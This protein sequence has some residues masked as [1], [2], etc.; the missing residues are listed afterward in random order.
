MYEALVARVRYHIQKAEFMGLKEAE[1]TLLLKET[2]DAIEELQS[3]KAALNGTVTNLLEQIKDLGKPRWIPVTERLPECEGERVLVASNF[4][5]SYLRVSICY[6]SKNLE[7]VDK[8]DF[9]GEKRSG[10]Y[11]RDPGYG[12]YERQCVRYWM[13]LPEPPKEKPTCKDCQRE[14]QMMGLDM[15]ACASY[16][17]PK[18][19]S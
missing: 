17:P 2:A 9:D 10:F 5:T 1:S 7:D 13:P 12:Y 6:F 3:D 4:L 19:E 14:C 11:A 15:D 18:E 16:K 8:Y